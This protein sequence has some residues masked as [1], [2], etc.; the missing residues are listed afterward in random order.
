[1]ARVH[2]YHMLW[3]IGGCTGDHNGT[4]ALFL[5]GSRDAHTHRKVVH[6][7]EE[8][9]RMI[10]EGW[11]VCVLDGSVP[12][13]TYPVSNPGPNYKSRLTWTVVTRRTRE[14]TQTRK[15]WLNQACSAFL[16]RTCAH[17]PERPALVSS[18]CVDRF[19]EIVT[20]DTGVWQQKTR[21]PSWLMRCDQPSV[22]CS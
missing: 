16:L 13:S 17:T 8:W 15:L 20:T 4:L 7:L 11:V 12:L 22:L 21:I 6:S 2:F 18:L 3:L 14:R 9:E 1:M 5:I 19:A 10:G